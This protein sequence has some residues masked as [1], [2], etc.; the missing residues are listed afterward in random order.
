VGSLAHESLLNASK[1]FS[2]WISRRWPDAIWYREYPVA[3]RQVNG[4]IV[5]GFIDLLLNIPDGYI[6]I[7]HKRFSG[8]LEEAKEK[9]ASFAG[10][11]GNYA[12]A[13]ESATGEKVLWK[14]I[15]LPVSG[16]VME[17]R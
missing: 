11:L 2:S 3:L 6:I 9:A 14:G 4:T 7:D 5:S 17:V 1:R 8:N 16:Y 10:Q 13:V 15:H 12:E